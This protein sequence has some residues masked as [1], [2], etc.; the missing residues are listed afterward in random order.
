MKIKNKYFDKWYSK[1]RSPYERVFAN[2]NKRTRYTGIVK[3]Q[4][5]ACMEAICHNLKRWIVLEENYS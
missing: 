1:I 4:F 5:T 2:T 3:N